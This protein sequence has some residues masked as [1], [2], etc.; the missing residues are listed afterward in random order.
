MA[1]MFGSDV[2][3]R[4]AG[5]TLWRARRVD[6]AVCFFNVLALRFAINTPARGTIARTSA[7]NQEKARKDGR[8]RRNPSEL[9]D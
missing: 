5:R 6:D 3:P 7:K 1:R 9:S 8:R 2:R 4:P